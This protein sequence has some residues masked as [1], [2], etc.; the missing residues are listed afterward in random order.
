MKFT[1]KL[2]SLLSGNKSKVN[3]NPAP[4]PDPE[5]EIRPEPTY[6]FEFEPEPA[7]VELPASALPRS[8]HD[9]HNYV[10]HIEEYYGKNIAK[11]RG[12]NHATFLLPKSSIPPAFVSFLIR[13][14]VVSINRRIKNEKVDNRVICRSVSNC[15][16]IYWK[17]ITD[18]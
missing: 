10:H 17:K 1:K 4:V 6:E 13:R 8:I 9:I 15:L 12:S 3:K 5:P 16:L 2:S 11:L 18:D 7:T 14:C